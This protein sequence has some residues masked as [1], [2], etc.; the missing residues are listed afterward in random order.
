[1]TNLTKLKIA[2][3]QDL[4]KELAFTATYPLTLS[5]VNVV[6]G[7]KLIYAGGNG[8][9][10]QIAPFSQVQVGMLLTGL[11]GDGTTALFAGH[12]TVSSVSTDKSHI[13]TTTN[14]SAGNVFTCTLGALVAL[15][16]TSMTVTALTAP[17]KKGTVL[18]FYDSTN[19]TTLSVIVSA[20]AA[21]GATTVSIYWSP[22]A[23]TTAMVAKYWS[24]TMTVTPVIGTGNGTTLKTFTSTL[25]LINPWDGTQGNAIQKG[26]VTVWAV[27]STETFTDDGNGNLLSSNVLNTAPG[28]VNYVTGA[29]TVNFVT[30]PP[31]TDE[32]C[33]GYTEAT[34]TQKVININ[35]M[36]N[37]QAPY[38]TF[39]EDAT[40][41][42]QVAILDVH[43]INSISGGISGNPQ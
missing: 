35:S 33:A 15:G 29:I 6:T 23:I 43:Q 38:I 27:G 37:T 24:G 7:V 2:L 21:I 34:F 1:M 28:T 32:V 12:T 13:G 4:L 3:Q 22:V 8:L 9:A 19:T 16:A 10:D 41:H 39:T 14:A 36:L 30:A 42:P 18:S 40:N 11:A 20:T 31:N 26:T 25:F 17:I 5:D